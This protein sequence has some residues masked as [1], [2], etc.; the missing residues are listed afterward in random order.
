MHF[1]GNFLAWK[2]IL[3]VCKV[4]LVTIVEFSNNEIQIIGGP[5]LTRFLLMRFPITKGMENFSGKWILMDNFFQNEGILVDIFIGWILV[6]IFH[7]FLWTFIVHE[8]SSFL[9]NFRGHFWGEF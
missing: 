1:P 5:L 7:E 6:E 9:V 2:G 4:E 3:V 8:N